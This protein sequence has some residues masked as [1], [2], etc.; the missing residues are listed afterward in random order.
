[1]GNSRE[2]LCQLRSSDLSFYAAIVIAGQNTGMQIKPFFTLLYH[3]SGMIQTGS[4]ISFWCAD[5][6]DVEIFNQYFLN[7]GCQK[8]RH[9]GTQPDIF[10][11]EMEKR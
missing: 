8:G 4:N 2:S 6:L 1:M 5:G 7:I 11:P 10:K 9:G 3:S